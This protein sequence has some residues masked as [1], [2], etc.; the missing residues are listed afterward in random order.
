M[1]DSGVYGSLK[2][3]DPEVMQ[4]IYSEIGS[5]ETP[6]SSVDI[7]DSQ[8]E[9][10]SKVLELQENPDKVTDELR[11][12]V[13]KN[14]V[15]I[16]SAYDPDGEELQGKTKRKKNFDYIPMKEYLE[17]VVMIP[18]TE[19]FYFSPREEAEVIYLPEFRKPK[20]RRAAAADE[21]EFAKAA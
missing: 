6:Y 19:D 15:T 20:V 8:R 9:E 11:S 18:G 13:I 21:I 16:K 10:Y 14:P 7:G 1:T 4:A 3:P 12:P 5:L 17:E 2:T